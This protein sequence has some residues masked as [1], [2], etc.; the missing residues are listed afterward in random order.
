MAYSWTQIQNAWI[1]GKDIY[2]AHLMPTNKSD[3]D[4]MGFL[5]AWPAL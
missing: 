1:G 5:L 3:V 2:P 4:H